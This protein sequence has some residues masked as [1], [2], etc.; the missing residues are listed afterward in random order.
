MKVVV[1]GSSNIDMVSIAVNHLPFGAKQLEMP[2][3]CS[4]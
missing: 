2:I 3:L 4:P 1:V